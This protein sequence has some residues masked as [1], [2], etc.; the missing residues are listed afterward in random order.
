VVDVS[1]LAF[2]DS[3]GLSA[4]VDGHRSCTRL[5]GYL[6]LA[7]P[8]PFLRLMLAVVGVLGPVPVYDSVHAACIGN[9]AYLTRPP[10]GIPTQRT[11]PDPDMRY[12]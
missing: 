5:R 1:S 3:I 2:C 12:L 10:D 4:F 11:D 9:S 6:R 7:G 8:G